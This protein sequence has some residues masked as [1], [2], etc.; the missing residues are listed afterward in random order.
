MKNSET[1]Q[2]SVAARWLLRA[3]R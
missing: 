3:T 2:D 1:A